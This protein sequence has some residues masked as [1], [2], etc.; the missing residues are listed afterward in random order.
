[1]GEE[2]LFF[3][4]QNIIFVVGIV[5]MV[6]REQE[7]GLEKGDWSWRSFPRIMLMVLGKKLNLF[8]N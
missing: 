3:I 8:Q 6:I 4:M 1:M 5:T 2:I 7:L